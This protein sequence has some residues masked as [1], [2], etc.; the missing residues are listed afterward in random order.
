MRAFVVPGGRAART[1]CLSVVACPARP[2]PPCA[3]PCHSHA[4]PADAQEAQPW[5]GRSTDGCARDAARRTCVVWVLACR[6]T[7]CIVGASGAY[8]HAHGASR[9]WRRGPGV[10]DRPE[11]KGACETRAPHPQARG[12]FDL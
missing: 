8:G 11:E 10:A 12:E 1:P 4:V 9:M 5:P 3:R 6:R 7:R 2:Q